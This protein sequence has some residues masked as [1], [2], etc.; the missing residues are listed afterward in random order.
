MA[1]YKITR[2]GTYLGSDDLSHTTILRALAQQEARRVSAAVT[3]LTNNSGGT[4]GSAIVA[5]DTVANEAA[6]GSSLADKTT[7]E[8]AL[9]TVLDGLSEIIAKA[10]TTATALGLTTIT[11]NSGAT[12]AD[13]TLGAI[14]VSVTGATTGVQATE[15]TATLDA[16]D[17]MQYQ[18]ARLVNDI[19]EAVALPKIT[20]PYVKTASNTI[21]ALTVSGG[22]AADPSVSK[23]AIDAVL[24]DYR[25]N[26]KTIA[27][28]LIDANTAATPLVL[29]VR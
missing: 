11:D 29:A 14:T 16:L 7:T 3:A 8:A 9:N 28:K 4:E 24:V 18:A 21:A 10:N 27:E 19:L 1:T 25:N 6:S 20:V 15:T 26:I 13:G 17:N 22:T 5:H 2:G 12:S 23:A